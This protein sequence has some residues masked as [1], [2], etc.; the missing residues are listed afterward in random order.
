MGLADPRTV[1]SHNIGFTNVLRVSG[2]KAGI[3]TL[4]GDMGKGVGPAW[5]GTCLSADPWVVMAIALA[6]ILG[7]LWPIFLG[8]KGGKGV[9]TALGSV[10][11]ISPLIGLSLL[12]IWLA[13][14][15][16]WRYSSGAAIVAFSVF[17]ALAAISGQGLPFALFAILVSALILTR[18]TD[19]MLRL[20]NGTER[21]IGGSTSP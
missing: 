20:W 12:L 16:I 2:K 3:L 9:A 15:A 14:A 5:L 21:K 19:N 4:L 17:P 13:T 6:P 11:G 18:H 8:F 1:G 10:T 7:H